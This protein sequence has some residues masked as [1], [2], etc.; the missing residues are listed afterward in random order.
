MM[1][2]KAATLVA[3]TL[4][5]GVPLAGIASAQPIGGPPKQG[6]F[7]AYGPTQAAAVQAMM[8]EMQKQDCLAGITNE[9]TGEFANGTWFAEGTAYCYA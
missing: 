7:I 9:Q 3:A 6:S 5:A 4:L 1:F 2:K 8:E